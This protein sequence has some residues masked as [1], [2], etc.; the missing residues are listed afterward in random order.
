MFGTILLSRR[1][2]SNSLSYGLAWA[3]ARRLWLS[4]IRRALASANSLLLVTNA[5]WLGTA[6]PG[7]PMGRQS[8]WVH[9]PTTALRATKSSR[10]IWRTVQSSR[11]RHTVGVELKQ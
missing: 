4:P 10:L 8:R 2:V 1:T 9:L 5:F 7:R 11:L 3:A 6:R